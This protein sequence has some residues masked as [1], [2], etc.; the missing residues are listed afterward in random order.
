M[1]KEQYPY[2]NEDGREF[3]NMISHYSDDGKMI[4]Q[5]ETGNLYEEAVDLYPCR[6]TYKETDIPID[7][8]RV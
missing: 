3:E 4:R 5:I 1:L 8:D 6:F 2:V 7:E